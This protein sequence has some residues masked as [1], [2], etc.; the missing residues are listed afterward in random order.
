MHPYIISSN[1]D[2]DAYDIVDLNT[3]LELTHRL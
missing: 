2:N 1:N 3:V